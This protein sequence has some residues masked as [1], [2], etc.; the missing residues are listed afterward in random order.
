M[1][2]SLVLDILRVGAIGLVFV[3]HFD[4][5]LDW[6]VDDW[7][8]VKNFYYVSFGGV[9]VSIFLV[10]SGIVA[11]LSQATKPVVYHEYMFKKILRIY[12][13]YWMSVI[14]SM[15]AFVWSG[16]IEDGRVPEMFPNGAAA[17][18]VGSVTGFYSWM[19]LWGGPYNSPSW[20]IAL[21]MV[22]YA[23]FPLI[24]VA[25]RNKWWRHVTIVGLLVASVGSRY[26]VGREGLPFDE[27]GVFDGIVNMVYRWY[28]FLPGRPVDWFP[29]GRVFEFGLGV[30]LAVVVKNEW[31]FKIKLKWSGVIT[32]LSD[33]SF[34]LFLV[35]Y[36]FMFLIKMLEKKGMHLSIAI[37]VY[38]LFVFVA[39]YVLN[40]IDGKVPRKRITNYAFY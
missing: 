22:M 37:I 36:P 4:Q 15:G 21:I 31:W 33:Q 3:A 10:L 28:G 19:G 18:I 6:P 26:Y 30:Y 25:M 17:D 24:W 1:K 11:G 40:W 29:L 35:H 13:L 7:F 12:P 23:V 5:L 39:A 8:G 20:F 9:G 14:V 32:W 38:M 2:R 16:W 27:Q 34:G